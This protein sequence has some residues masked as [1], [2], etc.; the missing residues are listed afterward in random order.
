MI[1]LLILQ[2]LLLLYVT[3]PVQTNRVMRCVQR[4]NCY[5]R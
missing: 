2:M 5:Y 4:K 3:H 1:T